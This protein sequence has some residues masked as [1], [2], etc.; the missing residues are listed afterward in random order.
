M[1]YL[2]DGLDFDCDDNRKNISKFKN[3]MFEEFKKFCIQEKYT[4][5]LLSIKSDYVFCNVKQSIIMHFAECIESENEETIKM[6]CSLP[7]EMLINRVNNSCGSDNWIYKTD[8]KLVN[9]AL[10]RY[11][12]PVRKP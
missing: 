1:I 6:L 2:I 5:E 10:K 12:R 8:L 3:D 11:N 7:K 9:E 4:Y